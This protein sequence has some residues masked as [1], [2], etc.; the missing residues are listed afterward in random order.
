[1]LRSQKIKKYRNTLFAP[2]VA[3]CA[4][5]GTAEAV[6]LVYDSTNP[7][8]GS[9]DGLDPTGDTLDLITSETD[10]T[11]VSS[12]NTTISVGGGVQNVY[13]IGNG[14]NNTTNLGGGDDVLFLFGA[15]DSSLT[16]P[17]T[18]TTVAD[19][20]EWIG[21]TYVAAA[22]QEITE[23]SFDIFV[24]N[25]NGNAAR[26]SG[27]F[28]SVNGAGFTQFGNLIDN[29]GT[30]NI[31]DQ[32]FTD[33]LLISAGDTVELRIGFSDASTTGGPAARHTR[34]GSLQ[35]SAEA[36]PEPSTAALGLLGLSL[37][38]GRRRR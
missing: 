4:C 15:V 10:I 22:D 3:V 8:T 9:V 5:A 17:I 30:G 26:D 36:V 23:V 35:I 33:T 24:N 27:A 13:T 34:I 32:T 37:I 28:F 31:G 14:Q 16:S 11:L 38:I 6:V 18:T 20:G 1:M 12:A 21:T 29:N 25:F 19:T 2:F 7:V